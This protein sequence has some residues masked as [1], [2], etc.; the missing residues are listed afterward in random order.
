MK[1]TGGVVSLMESSYSGQWKLTLSFENSVTRD[2][3]VRFTSV[4]C[5][6]YV[7]GE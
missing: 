7:L 1:E 6:W 2:L 5:I 4:G 3:L